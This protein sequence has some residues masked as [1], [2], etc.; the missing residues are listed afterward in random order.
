MSDIYRWLQ[1]NDK[2]GERPLP[3]GLDQQGRY[4]T[5]P[6]RAEYIEQR[7]QQAAEACTEIGADGGDRD[8]LG[9]WRGLRAG[10][11]LALLCWAVFG[12]VV[13]YLWQVA[14]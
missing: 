11:P 9:L 3:A 8:G 5:R 1:V 14:P 12:A 4:D 7:R 13:A 6:H 10:L 2:R